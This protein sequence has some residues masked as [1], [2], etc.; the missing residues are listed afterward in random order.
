MNPV[1]PVTVNR[2][3]ISMWGPFTLVIRVVAEVNT[4]PCKTRN[5]YMPITLSALQHGYYFLRFTVKETETKYFTQICA[6]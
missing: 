4:G 2:V 3:Q 1:Y 6:M 5:F